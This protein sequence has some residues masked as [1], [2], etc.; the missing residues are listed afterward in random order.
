MFS[1][2]YIYNMIRKSLFFIFSLWGRREKQT[3][4]QSK[5]LS[6][7]LSLA[8]SSSLSLSL[9]LGD[10]K[11]VEIFS[12]STSLLLTLSKERKGI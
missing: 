2:G 6:F 3:I 7:S 10:A 8:L 5:H 12:L 1:F 9:T 4:A 11:T